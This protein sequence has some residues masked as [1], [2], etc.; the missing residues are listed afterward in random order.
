MDCPTFTQVWGYDDLAEF[1]AT[2]C[3][4][5]TQLGCAPA[6]AFCPSCGIFLLDI[7][8]TEA[9][10]DAHIQSCRDAEEPDGLEILSEAED[11]DDAS[12]DAAV[13]CEVEGGTRKHIGLKLIRIKPQLQEPGQIDPGPDPR[14]F[15]C[16]THSP[17]GHL[18]QSPAQ[19]PVSG[20]VLAALTDSSATCSITAGTAGSGTS[21]P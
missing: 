5:S 19:A 10:R 1:Q 21:A 8:S 7:G 14:S 2:Q 20:V 4:L 17:K 15:S 9:Q 18:L 11:S 12:D 13:F 16:Q 6:L 3:D